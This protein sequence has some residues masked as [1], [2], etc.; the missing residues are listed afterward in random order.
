MHTIN[1]DRIKKEAKYFYKNYSTVREVAKIFNVGKST[2]HKDITERLLSI[3]RDLYNKVQKV[4]QYNKKVRHIRGGEATRR[5][6]L[7]KKKDY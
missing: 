5:L 2:V 1:E 7:E 4:L 6:F 3:D